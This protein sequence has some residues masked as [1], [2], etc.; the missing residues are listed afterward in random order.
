MSRL[1]VAIDAMG[2][3]RH[4]GP[5]VEAAIAVAQEDVPVLLVGDRPRVEAALAV[6]REQLEVDGA[7]PIAVRHC[8]E[9]ITMDDPPA[10]AVRAKKGASMPVCF[11]LVLAGEASSVVSAGNSGAM[12]ACGLFK[13]K[14]IKGVDRPAIVTTFPTLR[15]SCCLLDMGANVDLRALNFVQFAVMGARY[16]AF[17]HDK[18]RPLVGILSNGTEDSKGTPL[19]RAA[20]EL[21]GAHA[22]PDFDYAGYVEGRAVFEGKVDVVVT[23]G[24][25]GN[26]ALKMVEGTA[27]ALGV[28]LR[29]GIEQSPLSRMGAAMMRTAFDEVKRRVHPDNYGGAPLL[30][31]NG[32]AVICHGSSSAVALANG[33]RA[34][35]RFAQRNVGPELAA[36]L[37]RHA[38]VIAAAK[39]RD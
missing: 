12:L 37:D 29:R 14:R 31:V 39:Q 36:S 15:G 3:D 7:L 4:P 19:T 17:E 18:E 35:H 6:A 34:A 30:G 23:D 21:L 22:S 20:H 25:T 10:A 26:V 32:V 5:E 13:Y 8:A 16:A 38:A 9:A 33:T 1:P 2:G 24:F 27:H 28:F 11:D